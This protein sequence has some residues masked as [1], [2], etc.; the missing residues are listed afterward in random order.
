MAI[1]N[2]TTNINVE[3]SVGQVMASLARHGARKVMTE[4]D[5][6]GNV[7][8]ICFILTVRDLELPFA[9]PLRAANILEILKKEKGRG[10]LPG[11]AARDINIHHARKVGWRILLNWIESQ[12]ALVEIG[13]VKL[14]EVFMPYLYSVKTRQTLYEISQEKGLLR[15]LPPVTGSGQ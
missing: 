8:A 1:K 11:L 13:M 10:R 6:Q 3:K 15:L 5:A 14:D 4:Y 2:Y 7:E 12:L 9:L